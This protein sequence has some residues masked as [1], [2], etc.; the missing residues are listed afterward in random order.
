MG[1]PVTDVHHI[2]IVL[3]ANIELQGVVSSFN[4]LSP[5]LVGVV[6]L[7]IDYRSVTIFAHVGTYLH[8]DNRYALHHSKMHLILFTAYNLGEVQR[9]RGVVRAANRL[10]FISEKSVCSLAAE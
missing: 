5:F 4:K 10:E 1:A 6:G 9:R 8:L 7:K 2:L 3:T